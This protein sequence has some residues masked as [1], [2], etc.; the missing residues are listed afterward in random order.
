MKGE[1]GKPIKG[2]Q[3]E[4]KKHTHSSIGIIYAI[5]LNQLMLQNG[6]MQREREHSLRTI[7]TVYDPPL[8]TRIIRDPY[9]TFRGLFIYDRRPDFILF[10]FLHIYT[11]DELYSLSLTLSRHTG[12]RFSRIVHFRIASHRVLV[13]SILGSR[14]QHTHTGELEPAYWC[15]PDK[16]FVIR[17]RARCVSIS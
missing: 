15:V 4:E 8:L 5:G 17:A 2:R 13:S 12:D 11:L 10:P 14:E 7:Q 1:V 9:F 6:L 3:E 16:K